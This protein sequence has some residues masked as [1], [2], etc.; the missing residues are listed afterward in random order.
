MGPS[1]FIKLRKKLKKTQK[2]IAPLLGVSIKTIHSYEQGLQFIP[3]YIEKQILYLITKIYKKNTQKN[4]W[5]IKKC[6]IKVKKNCPAWK[7]NSGELCWFING[8]I[9]KGIV[10]KNW[11]NKIEI[12]KKC[13]VL[14]HILMLF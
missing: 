4:C 8:T 12:C 6:P 11:K 9:C 5:T 13:E 14:E 10:H 7:F 1:E 2:Q 3:G